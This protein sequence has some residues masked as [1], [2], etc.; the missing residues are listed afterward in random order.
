PYEGASEAV[1]LLA[2]GGG[3]LVTS[4]YSEDRA[5][6]AEVVMGT[7][8]SHGRVTAVNAKVAGAWIGPGAVLPQLI[9]GGPGHA[10]GG[11]ELG[12]ARG[13]GLYLQRTAI[14]GYG[15]LVEYITASGVR[16]G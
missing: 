7:A 2:R 16:A 8:P 5:F 10:G 12:G 1:A 15:P 9:H 13:L 14:Q 11:E 4:V 3:G 6:A